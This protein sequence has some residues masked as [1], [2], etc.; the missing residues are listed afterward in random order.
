MEKERV[1]YA[2]GKRGG[3]KGRMLGE[4]EKRGRREGGG[5]C[6]ERRYA[7][8]SVKCL[9]YTGDVHR[10]ECKKEGSWKVTWLYHP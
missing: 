2:G 5:Q 3:M 6:W 8:L 1:V 7:V 4:R 10:W 9:Q